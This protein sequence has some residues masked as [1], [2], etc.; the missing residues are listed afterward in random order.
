VNE[1]IA[2]LILQILGVLIG[3]GLLNFGLSWIRRKSDRR[4]VETSAD[5]DVAT[6][7]EKADTARDR[8]IDQL[9]EDGDTNRAIIRRLEEKLTA[10]EDRQ[11]KMQLDFAEQLG[12]AHNENARLVTR[13]AQLTTDL[14]IC[15]RQIDEYRQQRFRG[16]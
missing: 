10:M 12:L 4:K 13:I 11:V 6:V 1:D 3:G 2:K 15:S 8:L 14:D 5:V 7:A 9:Q 16:P